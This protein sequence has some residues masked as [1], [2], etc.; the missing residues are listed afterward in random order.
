LTEIKDHLNKWVLPAYNKAEG[1]EYY[2]D[3]DI[4]VLPDL[5]ENMAEMVDMLNKM[6]WVSGNEKRLA[7]KYG[8]DTNPLMNEYYIPQNLIPLSETGISLNTD[9]DQSVDYR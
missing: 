9:T 2:I 8:E 5:A 4:S 6:W 3:F 7:T 1:K